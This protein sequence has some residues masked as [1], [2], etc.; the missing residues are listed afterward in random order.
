MRVKVAWSQEESK[1]PLAWLSMDP[2]T[3]AWLW[4]ALLLS[5]VSSTEVLQAWEL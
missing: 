4:G 2:S 3:E 1:N 5:A